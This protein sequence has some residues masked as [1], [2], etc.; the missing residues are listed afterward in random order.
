MFSNSSSSLNTKFFIIGV[1]GKMG[2][3]K[4]TV[5]DYLVKK[6]GFIRLAF[7][8]VLKKVCFD[9]FGVTFENLSL[10]EKN[11]KE[12]S[13]VG[14][15]RREIWQIF[16]TDIMRNQVSKY[17]PG[18]S[19]ENIWLN[20][21]KRQI[22]QIISKEGR[23]LKVVITDV[24]FE[25]EA[26]FCLENGCLWN[27][28]REDILLDSSSEKHHSSEKLDWICNYPSIT[29]IKNNGT[30]E[31]LYFKIETSFKKNL[32]AF[33]GVSEDAVE[34]AVKDGLL[35][36]KFEYRNF[37]FPVRK[38]SIGKFF[39]R[40]KNVIAVYQN[41]DEVDIYRRH[42]YSVAKFLLVEYEECLKVKAPSYFMDLASMSIEDSTKF[43]LLTQ[44][45]KL[46][47]S[48]F[49][50]DNPNMF[51]FSVKGSKWMDAN[52]VCRCS[53]RRQELESLYSF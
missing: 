31:D 18:L 40:L 20:A 19:D 4:D 53:P 43:P 27:I 11:K 30:M 3:G 34:D 5:G 48:R 41:E 28:T 33:R 21:V 9:L 45:K 16:G 26:K 42:V 39:E 32:N 14:F 29:E 15:S 23:F 12:D 46:I 50:K 25:N 44:N 37:V 10:E 7:A 47:Y 8:D 51:I 38:E 6:H 36:I 22:N 17:L 49:E 13:L 52:I 24:R 2:A 35:F 1:C